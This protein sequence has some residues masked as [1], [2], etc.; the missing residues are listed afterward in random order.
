MRRL[1]IAGLALSAAAALAIGV[2][3]AADKGKAALDDK[4]FGEKVRAYLVA[5]PE[6]LEEVMAALKV[7]QEEKAQASLTESFAAHRAELEHARN[8]YAAGT[9]PVTVV[10]FF[11]YRCPYCKVAAPQLPDFIK[12]HKEIRVVFKE[13]PILSETST[14]AAKAAIAARNQGKY[15]PVHLALMSA[16]D[17]NDE[18]IDKILIEN[19]VDLQKAKELDQVHALAEALGVDGTPAF[20][21]GGK[22]I[23]GWQPDA[24]AA[25]I[26]A[27]AKDH[28][29][30]QAK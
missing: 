7:K 14:H 10:E 24:L 26:K 19:G 28:A 13:F 18:S 2:A 21:V 25:A 8:D 23:A 27:G 15:M 30:A 22:M 16:K 12:A 4:A 20:V 29:V 11:D 5:H 1:L 6:V 17:L 3:A 9:G